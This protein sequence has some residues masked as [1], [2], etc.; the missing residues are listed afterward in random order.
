MNVFSQADCPMTTPYDAAILIGRFQPFHNGHAALLRE[1]LSIA[2][3][4]LVVI[5]S[6]FHAPTAKNPFSWEQRAEM[7]TACF[8]E[9]DRQRI[10]FIP[11]RDY[12]D[13]A[14]WAA[15]V[16][17]GVQ[18][19]LRKL[20]QP[21]PRLAL[22]G[23]QKDDSTYYLR[24]FPQWAFVELPRQGDIDATAIRRMILGEPD[25][26]WPRARM[27]L[28]PAVADWI[29]QWRQGIVFADMQEEYQALEAGKAQWGTGPFITLDAVVT[30]AGR[31][32]L[33]RRK[34]PPGKNLWAIPGGFLDGRER[35][36]QGAIRELKE[37]T[38]LAVPDAELHAALRAAAV[39]DHPDRSQRGRVIT[40]AYWFGL[41]HPVPPAV[42]GGD[43]AAEARWF[44]IESLAD[45][46]ETL[47]GDHAVILR[48]L[49]CTASGLSQ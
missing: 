30:A 16:E 5:G 18:D 38:H 9:A 41:P 25:A 3:H 4:A 47:A 21:A 26:A 28:P 31:V 22:A 24:L 32:L 46:E 29:A 44:P 27:L 11:I 17:S 45:M 43:D 12:F 15:A 39:F 23:F 34:Y 7:I 42:Q 48:D 36:L 35:L 14:R 19:A 40:H 1:T 6:A 10:C 33:I 49:L 13:D 2:G 37:E 20:G 8:S